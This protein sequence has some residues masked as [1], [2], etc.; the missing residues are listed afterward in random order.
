MSK[1]RKKL[2][3]ITLKRQK[4]N[5]SLQISLSKNGKFTKHKDVQQFLIIP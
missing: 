4:E 3:E 2:V 1:W 5:P